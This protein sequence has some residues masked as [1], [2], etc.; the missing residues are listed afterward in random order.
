M[1]SNRQLAAIMF[2]DIVGYTEL[3]GKDEK[4]AF[5]YL[6][7][8]RQIQK[9]IIEQFNGRWIKELGDGVMASFHT[10]SDAVKAA[11]K[12]QQTCNASGEFKLR[13]GIHLGEVVFENDDVFGDGVNIASRIQAIATPGSIFV[14]EPVHNNISNKV[15]FQTRIVKETTL[16]NVK[17]PVKIYQVIAD[18]VIPAP[19]ALVTRRIK[20]QHRVFIVLT[21]MIFLAAGFFIAKEFTTQTGSLQ[22][23]TSEAIANSIAI[24]PF[25]NMSGDSTQEY[26]SDGMTESL[27]TDLARIP[28]LM[29]ISRNSVFQYKRRAVNPLQ[30]GKELNVNYILEGSVQRAGDHVRINAQLIDTKTGFHVWANKFDRTIKDIFLVQDDISQHIIN[31]LRI[32]ITATDKISKPPTEN[33]EA[34]EKYLQGHYLFR[35]AAADD[36]ILIDSAIKQFEEAASLDPQFALAYAGL[37]KA[38]V[39]TFFVYDPDPKWESKAFVAIE[40]SLSLN[41]E[42]AEAYLAKGNLTWTLS[43]GFPHE[44]AIM[45]LKQAIKLNPNL[46]EAHESLGGIYFHIGLLDEGLH[47][48]R[49]ALQLDPASRHAIPRVARIHW[50]QQKFDL[51]LTEF[52][53]IADPGPGWLIEKALVLWYLGKTDEAFS[54][55]DQMPEK[56]SSDLAAGYAVLL[57]GVGKKKEAEEKIEYA[58]THGQGKSHFHHAEH[59]IASAY[60]LMGDT[61][62]AV[63]WLQKAAEHGMPCYPLFKKDPN[64]KS[65]RNDA[66]YISLMEKLKRQMELHKAFSQKDVI[67]KI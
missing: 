48:L 52:S 32:A 10:V 36:R 57:A 25:D 13:I 53:A 38:L 6:N 14:S 65:I 22:A 55:L 27:I 54:T 34:Y 59:L 51:S 4:K 63:E 23:D 30:V 28:G 16:R 49:L 67:S 43:N 58:I 33:L 3:M 41:P 1:A 18:G 26:F 31:S 50:Y 11:V 9:P 47:E 40:K 29:V 19:S 62:R 46:V 8:N 64:L 20:T 17:E 39:T 60:A 56:E 42:L 21:I 66:G 15:D 12:I 61:K 7:K 2:T 35:R 45:E 5:E 44:K 24:L 37:A